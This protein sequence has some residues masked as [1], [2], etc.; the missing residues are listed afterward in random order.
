MSA[1]RNFI[2]CQ[3]STLNNLAI[4]DQE[5]RYWV[6]K[7]ENCWQTVLIY[8]R[9]ILTDKNRK[10]RQNFKLLDIINTFWNIQIM[11]AKSPLYFCPKLIR[12]NK[13]HFFIVKCAIL[14]HF[15]TAK[16]I[17]CSGEFSPLKFQKLMDPKKK[18]MLCSLDKWKNTEIQVFLMIWR[19]LCENNAGYLDINFRKNHPNVQC[20]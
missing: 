5:T 20:T 8:L 7:Q 1:E 12:I 6:E 11:C 10:K 13:R 18:M 4:F 9:H 17:S 19:G 14:G 2:K 16:Y 3:M 15:R